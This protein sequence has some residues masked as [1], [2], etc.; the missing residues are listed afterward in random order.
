M[1]SIIAY[2]L[3]KALFKMLYLQ[4]ITDLLMDSIMWTLWQEVRENCIM[5]IFVTYTLL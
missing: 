2:S 3:D 5:R 4:I 1:Y